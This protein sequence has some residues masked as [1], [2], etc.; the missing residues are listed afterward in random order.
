MSVSLEILVVPSTP[1]QITDIVFM[2]QMDT[3]L[4]RLTMVYFHMKLMFIQECYRFI[5]YS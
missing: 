1:K 3:L 2:E 4:L 5:I